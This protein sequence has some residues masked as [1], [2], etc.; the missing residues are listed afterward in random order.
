MTPPVSTGQHVVETIA[1]LFPPLAIGILLR[2]VFAPIRQEE[3]CTTEVLNMED[4]INLTMD[5]LAEDWLANEGD[6]DFVDYLDAVGIHQHQSHAHPAGERKKR[7]A[8]RFFNTVRGPMVTRPKYI[9]RFRPTQ[10][11]GGKNKK[12]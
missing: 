3:L 1:S 5:L 11:P 12:K 7:E 10:R 9:R 2:D 8:R 4:I 6:S